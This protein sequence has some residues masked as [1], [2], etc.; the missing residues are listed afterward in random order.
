MSC[1]PDTEW[2]SSTGF[3]W[4]R[5]RFDSWRLR[6]F[7]RC[8]QSCW[9]QRWQHWATN[10]WPLCNK[11]CLIEYSL[12]PLPLCMSE[13]V[14][15]LRQQVGKCTFSVCLYSLSKWRLCPGWS[16]NLE[17]NQLMV[18]FALCVVLMSN[19]GSET[20]DRT[21]RMLRLSMVELNDKVR[22][23]PRNHAWARRWFQFGVRKLNL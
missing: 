6:R 9:D 4:T 18:S 2:S 14:R 22:S 12:H 3:R 16:V 7:G 10:S 20:S 19:W 21:L 5:S 8:D 1:P 23:I 13:L 15:R 11:I 17:H